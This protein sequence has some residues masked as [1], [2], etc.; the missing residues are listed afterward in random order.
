MAMIGD[1]INDA[2]ALTG[3]NVGIAVVSASDISIQVSDILLT[4]GSFQVLAL[5]REVACKGQRIVKQNLFWAFFYNVIGIPI[6]AGVLFLFGGPLLSPVFAALAM[7]FS[8]VTV[9]S[10][11]LRLRWFRA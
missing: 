11:A 10:N 1:G 6:A 2:P 3:A 5:L 8:S 7:S 4:T 9:V